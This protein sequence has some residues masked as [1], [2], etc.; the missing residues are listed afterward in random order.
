M[1]RLYLPTTF[2]QLRQLL[3]GAAIDPG[4]DAVSAE[5]DSEE[6]EYAALMTAADASALRSAA[7]G[8]RAVLV[9]EVVDPAAPVHLVDVVALHADTEDRGPDA[10]PDDDLAW[11]ASQE[12]DH[13][14]GP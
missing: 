2:D 1:T 10:D 9:V 5:N 13:L 7:T 3:A 6:A 8:R 11:F 12:I 14:L 4:D